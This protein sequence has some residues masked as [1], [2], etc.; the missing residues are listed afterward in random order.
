MRILL[1]GDWHCVKGIRTQI[2]LDYLDEITEYYFKNNIDKIVVLG[3]VMDKSSSIKNEAFI[4]LF[5]KLL[6]M[7]EL[8]I[9]FVFIL[10]N[11]DIFN[12]DNDS[13][14][15]TFTPI[16]DV[17]K[18][19]TTVEWDGKEVVLLPYTKDDRDLPG[20][21][22]YLMTHIPIADF[23]FDNAYHATEKHAFPTA[24]VEEVG[25]VLTGHFHTY[26]KRKNIMYVGSPAQMNRGEMGHK[27]G[28]VV[29][30]TNYETTEF[31]E[32]ANAPQY[33]QI[34]EDDIKNI[35]KMDFTNKFVVVKITRQLKD[36]AKLRYVLYEKGA[37]DIIP[38][39]E[40]VEENDESIGD[41]V[42]TNSSIE[43]I[44]RNI[45]DDIDGEKLDKELLNKLF[46]KVLEEV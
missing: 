36:F 5:M 45:I 7:K 20:H 8:G 39:F 25:L 41:E 38:V 18:Q 4:P 9:N 12:I 29:L 43:T 21:C 23:Q 11:H 16:G 13:I 10:G 37:V 14:V 32:Y 22:D 28:F 24:S 27:K 17:I 6:K 34:T 40:K 42:E 3:D 33:I 15:E 30:D 26:Q 19:S 2:I 44:A 1:T 46:E 35:S 31:I